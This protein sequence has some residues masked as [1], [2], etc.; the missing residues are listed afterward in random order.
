M[1]CLL[2]IVVGLICLTGCGS[3]KEEISVTPLTPTPTITPVPPTITP[4]AGGAL[5]IPMHRPLTLNPLLNADVS[6]DYALKLVFEPLMT[7]DEQF[8]PSPNLGTF[9]FA[10]DGLSVSITLRDGLYWSDGAP[11]TTDD[12]TFSIDFLR[13]APDNAIYKHNIDNISPYY[14]IADD[15]KIKLTFLQP[16]SGMAY[17][18]CFPIIPRH[19]YE[20]ETDAASDKNMK[21]LGNGLFVFESYDN[22]KLM[23][24]L[25]N[26]STYRKKPY[27]DS[28]EAIIVPNSESELNA[29]DQRVIDL[30]SSEIADW[31]KYHGNRATNI[32]EFNTMFYDFIGFNFKND[33]FANKKLRQALAHSMN[34]DDMLSV[35]YLG[36]AVRSYTP[37]N[38]ASWLY[39]PNTAK[40][41]LNLDYAANL[42]AEAGYT[43]QEPLSLR[44]LVNEENMER[45]KICESLEQNLTRLGVNV[46]VDITDFDTYVSKLDAGEFDVF[47]GGYSISPAQ[48]LSFML[49]SG[50]TP[51]I[52]NYS[53]ENMNKLLTA[54]FIATGSVSWQ[55]AMSDLQIYIAEELPVI[56]LAFRKSAMLSDQKILGAKTPVENNIFANINAWYIAK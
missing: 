54:S 16:F 51:N 17:Q 19:Y 40:Y 21:P 41:D 39:E 9:N 11:I 6:V 56:S 50:D 33:A 45:V 30:V 2:I 32:D 49:K 35:I 13:D 25:L 52:F 15:K 55:K 5:K 47:I 34:V 44:L 29:F 20:G 24:L 8:K 42:L 26:S 43:S 4:S 10:S 28:I 1:K 27:I 22:T 53:D 12:V 14:V 18:L 31:S 37:V 46:T 38:P 48:E 36:H 7:I 23:I 3:A